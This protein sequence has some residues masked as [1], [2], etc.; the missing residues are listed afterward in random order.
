MLMSHAPHVATPYIALSVVIDQ[1]GNRHRFIQVTPISI[2]RPAV[3][4]E[5][6][7]GLQEGTVQLDLA[8]LPLETLRTLQT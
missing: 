5:V 8:M 2:R 3:Q 1:E 4:G 7:E 6:Q